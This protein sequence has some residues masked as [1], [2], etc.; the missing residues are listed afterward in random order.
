MARSKTTRSSAGLGRVSDDDSGFTLMEALVSFVLF[1][2]MATTAT[3]GLLNLIK[4]T[5]VTTNRT[6]AANLATQEL[7]RMRFESNTGHEVDS[8]P[9]TVKLHGITYT[10]TPSASP[11]ASDP[12]S[13]GSSRK[14]SVI[15]T[16]NS[17]PARSARYDSE[18]AC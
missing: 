11:A 6:T 8:V 9:Q 1:T 17:T 4:L 10:V 18:L 5:G 13:T 15:V 12:C 3:W 16:W 14:I 7:E 2:I